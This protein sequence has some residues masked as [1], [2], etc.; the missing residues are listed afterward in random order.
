[1]L[2]LMQNINPLTGLTM[3]NWKADSCC[4]GI[5]FGTKLLSLKKMVLKDCLSW[6]EIEMSSF[7]GKVVFFLGTFHRLFMFYKIKRNRFWKDVRLDKCCR[8]NRNAQRSKNL[9]SFWFWVKENFLYR[10]IF[11]YLW[12]CGRFG[13]LVLSWHSEPSV[14]I[15][16]YI[17]IYIL[18]GRQL[19]QKSCCKSH[20]YLGTFIDAQWNFYFWER[21]LCKIGRASRYLCCGV[22]L[23][24]FCFWTP[25]FKLSQRRLSSHMFCNRLFC[26]WPD[27]RCF[28]STQVFQKTF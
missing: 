19:P 28:N 6:L 26:T 14:S 3:C 10:K 9:Q 7:G 23:Q 2:L 13:S 18:L 17:Y 5:S 25:P 8:R 24:H 22:S 1:M 27:L 4:T 21:W 16:I 15:Y 11:F 12:K 20:S